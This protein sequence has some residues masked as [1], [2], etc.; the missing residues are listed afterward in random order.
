MEHIKRDFG[1]MEIGSQFYYDGQAF[2]KT[3]ERSAWSLRNNALRQEQLFSPNTE[4]VVKFFTE[5]IPLL[6]E[7]EL[8]RRAAK[9]R[10][11]INGKFVEPG[12]IIDSCYTW[13]PK[14][15][16]A[17]SAGLIPLVHILT[18][19]SFGY[20][21]VF[22]PSAAEVLACIS[23]RFLPHTVAFEIIGPPVNSEDLNRQQEYL[24]AG[25]H[26]ALTALFRKA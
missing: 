15:T 5:M 24:N 10:P 21:G 3:S 18:Y 6:T 26:Q 20:H 25:F 1:E 23:E 16:G 22:K 13:D 11:M 14:Y 2:K 9:I 12:N 4:V 19:H 8:H 7:E 17:S